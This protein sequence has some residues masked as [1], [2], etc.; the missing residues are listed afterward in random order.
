MTAAQDSRALK[1]CPFCGGAATTTGPWEIG[2]SD[3]FEACI[4]C[5]HCD[6][7][8]SSEGGELFDK[9]KA[10]RMASEKWNRRAAL[11]AEPGADVSDAVAFA[12][13]HGGRL[14]PAY[15][16][17]GDPV[18]LYQ[19]DLARMLA[20]APQPL[21]RENPA[22]N[23]APQPAA[24]A[25][26][27]LTDAQV[28]A[29]AEGS[30]PNKAHRLIHETDPE[31]ADQCGMEPGTRWICSNVHPEHSLA[32]ARAIERAHGITGDPA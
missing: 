16:K 30:L 28:F 8:I 11:S 32:F 5:Q 17:R 14:V 6:F 25:R 2:T 12:Q 18:L 15:G 22:S 23:A 3:R 4:E 24:Q 29:A 20:A 7:H 10:L 26:K 9:D 31:Y 21:S 1:P 19:D 13:T 27:P